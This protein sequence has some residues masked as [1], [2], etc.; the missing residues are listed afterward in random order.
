[1]EFLV[2]RKV[3]L[4]KFD[5]EKMLKELDANLAQFK[6]I[7]LENEEDLQSFKA[8][9]AGLNKVK[10][11]IDDERKRIK[12]EYQEPLKL[13]EE[14]V[15][16]LTTKID[17]VNFEIDKQIKE[18]EDKRKEEKREEIEDLFAT[19]NFEGNIKLED[20]F[21]E[22]WL[23]LTFSLKKIEEEMTAIKEKIKKDLMTLKTIAKSNTDYALL[24]S[25]YFKNFDLNFVLESYKERQELIEESKKEEE[26]EIKKEIN[27]EGLYVLKF[28]IKATKSQIKKLKGFLEDNKI[29]HE[30]IKEN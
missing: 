1:M 5:K 20:I 30:R 21:D 6:G 18:A 13:F 11:V 16:E 26:Q 24:T 10:A 22:K 15:K 27:S 12:K 28:K 29:E 17:E 4:I 23:N 7:K 25:D 8:K 14:D 2:E 9:R 19:L 3:G